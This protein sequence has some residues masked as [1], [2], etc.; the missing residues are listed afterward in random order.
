MEAEPEG[1]RE[2]GEHPPASSASSGLITEGA[3]TVNLQLLSHIT[4]FTLAEQYILRMKSET[5]LT[6]RFVAP[7]QKD[8]PRGPETD[9]ETRRDTSA[10]ALETGE[11]PRSDKLIPHDR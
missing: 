6:D 1:E 3:A 4:K 5:R 7:W 8:G 9:T 2:E 11:I 10:A